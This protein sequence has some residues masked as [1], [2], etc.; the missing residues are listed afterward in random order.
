MWLLLL[1]LCLDVVAALDPDVSI[2]YKRSF[3]RNLSAG[4]WKNQGVVVTTGENVG[5]NVCDVLWEQT[6]AGFSFKPSIDVRLWSNPVWMNEGVRHL[7]CKKNTFLSEAIKACLDKVE[8]AQAVP[9]KGFGLKDEPL[10]LQDVQT[11]LYPEG[12]TRLW[13]VV[14]KY[15]RVPSGVVMIRFLQSKDALRGDLLDDIWEKSEAA[16]LLLLQKNVKDAPTPPDMAYPAAPLTDHS[17]LIQG[18][19]SGRGVGLVYFPLDGEDKVSALFDIP[20]E[21]IS[22]L[23]KKG[24]KEF[25]LYIDLFA[26]FCESVL[27]G[28]FL[29]DPVDGDIDVESIKL[30][31]LRGALCYKAAFYSLALYSGLLE[32]KQYW[33]SNQNVVVNNSWRGFQQSH[34]DELVSEGNTLQWTPEE[35]DDAQAVF[36]GEIEPPCPGTLFVL[37]QA[38]DVVL[39][40]VPGVTR[41]FNCDC[42]SLGD[43]KMRMRARGGCART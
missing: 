4:F 35:H 1:L 21:K 22:I 38:Q 13:S 40:G 39:Q 8:E 34:F 9:S 37:L 28:L 14:P 27:S 23:Y 29:K 11:L 25:R 18:V 33:Q 10:S 3:R 19:T 36:D 17:C 32:L 20:H 42:N 24:G 31:P 2:T 5:R 43:Y 12:M 41:E 7:A 30:A 16:S 15:E 26:S 6:S